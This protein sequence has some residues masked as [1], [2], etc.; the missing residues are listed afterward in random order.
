MVNESIC[1][2]CANNSTCD[3]SLCTI[4][5]C[6]NFVAG[7]DSMKDAT[8]CPFNVA[9]ICA[10]ERPAACRRCGWD[11]K[12][13][14]KRKRDYREASRPLYRYGLIIKFKEERT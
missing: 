4:T 7:R 8:Q 2:K 9:V 12:V 3:W 11:P 14:A 5:R 6:R 13:S 10:S 1:E